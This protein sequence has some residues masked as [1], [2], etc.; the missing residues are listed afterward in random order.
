MSTGGATLQLASYGV[1]DL[2]LTGKPQVTQFKSVVKRHTNFSMETVENYFH[3]KIAPGQKVFCDIQRCGDLISQV[4]LRLKLPKLQK[5]Q[6]K[7][8]IFTSWVNGIGFAIVE[9]V[10]IQI[11]ERVIDKQY[12]DWM[13]I[14]TELSEDDATR[15][16]LASMV[17]GHTVFNEATQNG[18][19][20]LY[21]PFYFWFCKDIGSSL[22][23]VALQNQNVRITVKFRDLDL[24]WTS[25]NF[26]EA[27]KRIPTDLSFDRASLLVDYIFLD[28]D[29]RR[30][31][32]QNRHFYLI[33]QVQIQNE[34]IDVNK[35][36]NVIYMDF[37]HP[38]KEIYWV[39]QGQKVRRLNQWFN[40]TD[41]LSDDPVAPM[42]SAL[43]R[44]NGQKRFEEREERYFRLVI[45]WK[46]HT[47]TPNSFI[48]V[49]D[50]A[51]DPERL[52]PTGSANFS[53]IDSASLHLHTEGIGDSQVTIYAL[54]YNIFRIIGGISGVVFND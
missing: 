36:E 14:W 29:E 50:F 27:K 45:P 13:F 12:G 52:Q 33:E 11:G 51:T 53:R 4:M 34:S 5:E 2:Y 9:Y 15:G 38:V 1:Q 19:L 47:A 46:R 17:G 26:E 8:G 35:N 31:F 41:D 18:P 20:D 16:G 22:P 10:E 44:F 24:L 30:Y 25:N 6:G 21:V 32:A 28:V 49:Y 43:I 48:Y 39:I 37:N 23:L 40:F 7:D 3:G 54:N 42:R